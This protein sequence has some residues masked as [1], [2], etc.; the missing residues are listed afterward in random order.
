VKADPVSGAVGLD[1]DVALV[2][3]YVGANHG[4]G[5]S[6]KVASTF[7]TSL[8]FTSGAAGAEATDTSVICPANGTGGTIDVT[9]GSCNTLGTVV[10]A[11]N[12]SANWRAV[13]MDGFR[14]DSS[15]LIKTAAA[16]TANTP[17]GLNMVWKTSSGTY[18]STIAL[19]QYRDMTTYIDNRN[20]QLLPNPFTGQRAV[21]LIGNATSTFGAGTSN[22]SVYS[23]AETYNATLGKEVCTTLYTT[24]GGATT[25][26]QA[27]NYLP[28]GILGGKNQKVLVRLTNSSAMTAIANYAF[29]LSWF[30]R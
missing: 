6:G 10:D 8:V 22:W 5:A 11:I 14:T 4:G 18:W 16:A 24:A 19:T 30:F 23:C 3:K 28:Y 25:V 9:N 26:N 2:I 17:A 12:A 20:D 29:G 27:F 21:F 1:Q 13:I 15:A 7:G